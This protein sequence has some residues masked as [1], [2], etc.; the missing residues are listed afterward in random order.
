MENEA[1]SSQHSENLFPKHP[2]VLILQLLQGKLSIEVVGS[3]PPH[4]QFFKAK[5]EKTKY[6]VEIPWPCQFQNTPTFQF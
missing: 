5:N 6:L 4:L 3:N 1:L 2:L